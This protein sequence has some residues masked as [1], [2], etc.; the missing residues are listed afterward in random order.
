M[1]HLSLKITKPKYITAFCFV[2]FL[3]NIV[4]MWRCFYWYNTSCLWKKTIQSL[5]DSASMMSYAEVKDAAW[6]SN[7]TV[8]KE[9]PLTILQREAEKNGLYLE[10]IHIKED[11]SY[12]YDIVLEGT[13]YSLIYFLNA[14]EKEAPCIRIELQSVETGQ[15]NLKIK[16]TAYILSGL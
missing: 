5:E 3:T 6:T 13:Y 4:F 12:F 14:V 16:M 1:L 10:T 7:Y 2:L 8:P 11:R 15:E 9:M